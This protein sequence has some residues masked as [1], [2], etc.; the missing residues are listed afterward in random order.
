[1]LP[2]TLGLVPKVLS[3]SVIVKSE[4]RADAPQ[5]PFAK[6]A[7]SVP[8]IQPLKVPPLNVVSCFLTQAVIFVAEPLL[9]GATLTALAP[10]GLKNVSSL[11]PALVYPKVNPAAC[12]TG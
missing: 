6:S 9:A 1:V 10:S 3:Y 4:I 7:K 5:T 12:L 2:T 8:Q 11:P